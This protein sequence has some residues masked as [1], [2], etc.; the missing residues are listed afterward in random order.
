MPAWRHNMCAGATGNETAGNAA[1]TTP[2][3]PAPPEPWPWLRQEATSLQH[4]ARLHASHAPDTPLFMHGMPRAVAASC[5]VLAGCLEPS[6]CIVQVALQGRRHAQQRARPGVKARP[7][8]QAPDGSRTPGRVA[9]RAKWKRIGFSKQRPRAPGNRAGLRD[10]APALPRR[11]A[12]WHALAWARSRPRVAC[13]AGRHVADLH[14]VEPRLRGPVAHPQ[15]LPVHVG[16]HAAT[17][18]QREDDEDELRGAGAATAVRELG[19]RDLSSART[20]TPAVRA[21]ALARQPP[22]QRCE[23][24]HGSGASCQTAARP[25]CS[26]GRETAGASSPAGATA[27]AAPAAAAGSDR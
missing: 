26:V 19:S 1:L 8:L 17:D 6:H 18:A 15:V 23:P 13:T 12:S 14:M 16:Q 11:E 7:G 22:A 5:P 24:V 10:A 3:T 4:A 27:G 9:H 25:G 21:Y 20:C 2:S